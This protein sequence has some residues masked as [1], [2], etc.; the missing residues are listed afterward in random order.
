M[1]FEERHDT[2]QKEVD[3]DVSARTAGRTCQQRGKHRNLL[4]LFLPLPL[5]EAFSKNPLINN[6]SELF[7]SAT[8]QGGPQPSANQGVW[9][10][11]TGIE[12]RRGTNL[13]IELE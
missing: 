1:R 7:S 5:R 3:P 6:P 8:L 10:V 4:V 9:I 2:H 13:A 11:W 12:Y